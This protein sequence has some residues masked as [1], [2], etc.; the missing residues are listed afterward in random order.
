[1]TFQDLFNQLAIGEFA[2]I[3][4]G[5]SENGISLENQKKLLPQ[6]N[7]GLI[8]LH[9]RFFLRE[10]RTRMPVTTHMRFF[11]INDP[12]LLK[13]EKV[14]DPNDQELKIDLDGNKDSVFLPEWNV[15]EV[16][17]ELPD[18]F[19]TISYRAKNDPIETSWLEKLGA[20]KLALPI[21]PTH[22]YALELFVASQIMTPMGFDG[23][24]HEG[25]N[26]LMKFENACRQLTEKGF[27]RQM[28]TEPH[29]FS[30]N[31]WV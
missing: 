1:M 2:Q 6:I 20:D 13:V 18:G 19:Y 4:L 7:L 15:V 3:S 5:D 22:V 26:Y 17:E 27:R 23:E 10:K 12:A 14:F 9:K 21:P 31:G 8:E 28:E 16:P 24:M 11:R 30:Q 25:N 29:S